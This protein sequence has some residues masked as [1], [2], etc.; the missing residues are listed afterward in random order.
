MATIKNIPNIK[1][2][3]DVQHPQLSYIAGGILL[4]PYHPGNP[5]LDKYWREMNISV[6]K[7]SQMQTF[8]ATL[9]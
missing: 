9:Q 3:K 5:Y 6:Y 4:F 1:K 7:K 8:T 2:K